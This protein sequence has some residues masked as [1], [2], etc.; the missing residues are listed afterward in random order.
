MMK[1]EQPKQVDAVFLA[2]KSARILCSISAKFLLHCSL[3]LLTKGK[4]GVCV[5]RYQDYKIDEAREFIAALAFVDIAQ[6]LMQDVSLIVS[7]GWIL[8]GFNALLLP[9]SDI[10]HHCSNQRSIH[11]SMVAH[12]HLLISIEKYIL[13]KH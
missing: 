2:G 6:S 9:T 11:R 8:S 5:S 13:I 3:D 7:L 12:P 10:N 4:R 1:E